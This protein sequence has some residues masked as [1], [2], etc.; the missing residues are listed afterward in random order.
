MANWSAEMDAIHSAYGQQCDFVIKIHEAFHNHSASATA[1]TL[2][3]VLP[4]R[5]DLLWCANNTLAFA[6]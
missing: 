1:S 3:C 5:F 4:S 6:R 2:L